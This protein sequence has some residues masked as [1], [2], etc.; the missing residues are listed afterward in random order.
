MNK[1]KALR[2]SLVSLAGVGGA[3]IAAAVVAVVCIAPV[4]SL[5]LSAASIAISPTE[6]TQSRICPGGLVDIVSRNSDA[7][8]FQG[9]AAPTIV[10]EVSNSALE[11]ATIEAPDNV[12]TDA[13]FAPSVI[14]AAPSGNPNAPALI[15]GAQSQE[16]AADSISGLAAAACGEGSTDQWIVGGSTEVGRTSLL[17]LTNSL[18]V[19]STATIE[20]FGEK[21]LVEAAGMSGIVVKA[22]SQHIISLAA[23]APNVVEPVVHVVTTGGQVLA[24]LQQ[25]VTRVVTPGGVELVQPGAGPALRQIIPGVALNGMANQDGEGGA[26]TNDV[27]P[28]IRV[29]VPGQREA[30][31]TASISAPGGKPIVVKATVDAQH[32]LQLPF[33]GVPDGIYT[34]VVT[35]E[36]PIVAGVRTVQGALDPAA[37]LQPVTPTPTPTPSVKAGAAVTPA[38][39]TPVVIPAPTLMGG[40]FTWHAAA[41]ALTD[42]TLLS[43]PPGPRPTLTLFNPSNSAQTVSI[44]QVDGTSTNVDVP[45]GASVVNIIEAGARLKLTKAKGVYAAVTLQGPGRGSA[46]AVA[47]ASRLSSAITVYPH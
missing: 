29:L 5:S 31:V 6:A 37:P 25:T 20:I 23:F 42:S 30:N 24:T 47:P 12:A 34:V 21:G 17:F 40:D 26:I 14:S 13:S 46:F 7:T 10:T 36:V 3:L 8:S 16:A 38:V 9:F 18:D 44:T 41:L 39:P 15:V 19:D 43:V 22:R 27:A 1:T 2:N 35:A 32:T 45:A 28:A 4:P 11:S 33:S